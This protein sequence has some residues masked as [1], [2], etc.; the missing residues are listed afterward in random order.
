MPV[1]VQ[2][3]PYSFGWLDVMPLQFLSITGEFKCRANLFFAG[4]IGENH[5][6]RL[7]GLCLHIVFIFA[8][9]V[10]EYLVTFFG[11]FMQGSKKH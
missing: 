4:I 8:K 10:S 2:C 5:K 6:L 3:C 7:N 11:C 9:E 1:H